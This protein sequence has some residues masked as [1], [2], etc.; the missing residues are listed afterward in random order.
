MTALRFDPQAEPEI[1][2]LCDCGL[3]LVPTGDPGSITTCACGAEYSYRPI[4]AGTSDANHDEGL[5]ATPILFPNFVR[6]S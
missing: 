5:P 1:L 4:W 2:R 3:P 6:A